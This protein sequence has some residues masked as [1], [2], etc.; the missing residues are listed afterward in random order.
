MTATLTIFLDRN[1][2]LTLTDMVKKLTII[3]NH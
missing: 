3:V 1:S 2:L